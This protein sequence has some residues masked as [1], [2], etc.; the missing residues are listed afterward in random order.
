MIDPEIVMLLLKKQHT[1]LIRI[2]S[3]FVLIVIEYVILLMS[4][5][6]KGLEMKIGRIACV[7]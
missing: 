3:P 4:I 1:S 2:V 6:H 5:K 7:P